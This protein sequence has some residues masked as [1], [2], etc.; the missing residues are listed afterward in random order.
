M[1]TIEMITCGHDHTCI[2]EED[3]T[4]K[5]YGRNNKKQSNLDNIYKSKKADYISC[6]YQFTAIIFEDKHF[7]I[8]GNNSKNQCKIDYDNIKISESY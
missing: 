8:F 6:G 4:V 7:V 2:I 1:K 5:L 3:K